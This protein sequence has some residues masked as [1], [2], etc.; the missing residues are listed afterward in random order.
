[1]SCDLNKMPNQV[2]PGTPGRVVVRRGQ[3]L[4]QSPESA[5]SP[6]V[7]GSGPSVR[8]SSDKS[9][10][11]PPRD[12]SLPRLEPRAF[13]PVTPKRDLSL[14]RHF[15]PRRVS[16]LSARKGVVN[17]RSGAA[18]P[19]SDSVQGL[20][21][22]SDFLAAGD[23]L[24]NALERMGWRRTGALPPR[25]ADVFRLFAVKS[26]GSVSHTTRIDRAELKMGLTRLRKGWV[27]ADELDS[28]LA[29][30]DLE[31]RGSLGFED[32]RA[33]LLGRRL[34]TASPIMPAD[35]GLSV[36]P[37]LDA[38][39][40]MSPEAVDLLARIR[41]ADLLDNNNDDDAVSLHPLAS[42]ALAAS[43]PKSVAGVAALPL[44]QPDAARPPPSGTATPP[45]HLYEEQSPPISPH[46]GASSSPSPLHDARTLAHL[47]HCNTASQYSSETGTPWHNP[48]PLSPQVSRSYSQSLKRP[49]AALEEAFAQSAAF[50]ARAAE[51]VA[52]L[53][54]LVA[55]AE[56]AA[57]GC[58]DPFVASALA[59][60]YARLDA[61]NDAAGNVARAHVH[62]SAQ[63]LGARRMVRDEVHGC[64]NACALAPL[65]LLASAPL[66][67]SPQAAEAARVTPVS[68]A[69]Y[70][71]SAAL[72]TRHLRGLAASAVA[73]SAAQDVAQ[74]VAQD[75][76]QDVAQ[77]FSAGAAVGAATGCRGAAVS[78]ALVRLVD[79]LE[80]RLEGL[81][82]RAR[83]VA[84]T[85]ERLALGRDGAERRVRAT[86]G[87]RVSDSRP[88]QPLT[89]LI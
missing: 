13:S 66:P 46:L 87:R 35:H 22:L 2:S 64:R 23:K 24:K 65:H 36:D 53:T 10:T 7:G 31:G 88:A 15:T 83:H 72:V 73:A 34:P 79:S 61:L 26:K 45:R 39:P 27:D 55:G 9:R 29:A 82:D 74:G 32:F 1:M 60:L 69:A 49:S 84:M 4:G 44:A 40:G 59:G 43:T 30:H 71:A 54:G 51:A 41:A 18:L 58:S 38:D 5:K 37:T 75:V 3:S 20:L 76:T 28:V 25:E 16:S 62:F 89:I 77:D 6:T 14:P 19:G 52:R 85:H 67:P 50:K 47:S 21:R 70:A 80:L 17:P 42:L 86:T 11:I 81:K 12:R 78:S 8:R 63:Y 57:R 33:F 56:V 48:R 68:S